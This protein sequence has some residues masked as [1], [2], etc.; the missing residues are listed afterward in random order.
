MGKIST[1]TLRVEKRER[2]KVGASMKGK[3]GA[4]GS[5]QSNKGGGETLRI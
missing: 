2:N 3:Q 1:K 5:A 4:K